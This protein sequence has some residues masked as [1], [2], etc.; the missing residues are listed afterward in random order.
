MVKEKMTVHQALCEIKVAE[1]KITKFLD[2]LSCI[3]CKK[4]NADKLCGISIEEFCDREK[5]NYQSVVD[6]IK[7]LNALKSAVN[8][9]NATTTITVGGEVY[10]IA[11]A[12]YMMQH[13]IDIEKRLIKKLSDSY[14]YAVRLAQIANGDTLDE[15]AERAAQ[16]VFSTDKG[17]K[18]KST[19]KYLSFIADYKK[20]NQTELVD[21]LGIKEEIAKRQERVD[22]FEANVD[23]AIQVSNATNVIEVEY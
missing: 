4:A 6:Q 5:R 9:Y 21:P 23:A 1:K 3:G 19:E 13:G 18:A 10:S 15:A 20:E 2:E 22:T 17:E 11:S 16:I 12:V 14:N 8:H 7:R